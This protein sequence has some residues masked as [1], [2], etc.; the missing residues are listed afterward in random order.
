M[1]LPTAPL[2]VENMTQVQEGLFLGNIRSVQELSKWPD[3]SWLVVSILSSPPMKKLVACQLEKIRIEFPSITV[4][5][6]EWRLEDTVQAP[7]VSTQL[8]Q[9]L[10]EMDAYI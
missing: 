2:Q 5:H 8:E 7:F 1:E 9:V 3:R 10:C 4:K 6:V